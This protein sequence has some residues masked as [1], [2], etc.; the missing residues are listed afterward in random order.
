MANLKEQ[1][2]EL[3][4]FFNEEINRLEKEIK[5]IEAYQ[6]ELDEKIKFFSD[7][8]MRGS[9][10]YYIEI[11]KN[12]IQLSSLKKDLLRDITNLKKNI[13]DY[14]LKLNTSDSDRP[15]VILENKINELLGQLKKT[16]M[17]KSSMKQ[18]AVIDMDA[19][20]E[21]IERQLME[22]DE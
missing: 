3:F 8:T 10:H 6:N 16:D 14:S 20:D 15:N 7:P 1:S 9:T 11:G 13:L 21:E 12:Q 19:L 2:K 17:E 18:I 5:R 4:N 22:P